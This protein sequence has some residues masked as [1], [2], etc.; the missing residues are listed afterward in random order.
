[1]LIILDLADLP[2][3]QDMSIIKRFEIQ[4][5]KKGDVRVEPQHRASF[6]AQLRL[7]CLM[8]GG[9]NAYKKINLYYFNNCFNLKSASSYN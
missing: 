1:M 5:L 9:I 6:W 8:I 4:V 7:K 3:K 2:L